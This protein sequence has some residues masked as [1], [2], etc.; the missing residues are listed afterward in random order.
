MYFAA[1]LRFDAADWVAEDVVG[2]RHLLTTPIRNR[3]ALI[4]GLP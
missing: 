1:E 3:E 2:P 4:S